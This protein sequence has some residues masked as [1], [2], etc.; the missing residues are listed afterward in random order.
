MQ[1]FSLTLCLF[2]SCSVSL[3]F[4]FSFA[5]CVIRSNC[6]FQFSFGFDF[7][8]AL[9]ILCV[10]VCVYLSVFALYSAMIYRIYAGSLKSILIMRKNAINYALLLLLLLS[11]LLSPSSSL[12]F[13][14]HFSPIISCLFSFWQRIDLLLLCLAI[15]AAVACSICRQSLVN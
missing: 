2:L 4:L 8:L 12:F 11:L 15:V 7:G 1:F 9:R 10:C 5:F 14:S 3:S 13:F 6:E